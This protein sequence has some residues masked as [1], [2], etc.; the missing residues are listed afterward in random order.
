MKLNEYIKILKSKNIILFDYQYRLSHDKIKNIL[1][2]NIQKG[3]AKNEKNNILKNK[4]KEEL[5]DIIDVALNNNIKLGYLY[6]L[7]NL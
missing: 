5:N 3:G 6:Y 4:T 1:S 7:L 2:F